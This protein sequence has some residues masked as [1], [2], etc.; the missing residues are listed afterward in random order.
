MDPR[1][2]KLIIK[3]PFWKTAWFIIFMLLVSALLIFWLIRYRGKQ[4]RK[5]AELKSNY[6]NKM[7][8]LEMQN[9]RSQMNPHFIFNSLNSINSFIVENKTHLASDYLTK[10]SKLI[11]LILDNSRNEVISL[12]RELETLQL[13]LLMETLRFDQKFGFEVT[14][15]EKL[16][17]EAVRIPPMIIQPYVENAIWHGLMQKNGKGQVTVALQKSADNQFLLIT[18][19]DNGVGR[20][21]ATQLSSKTGS[22]NKSFGMEITRNR[23][24]KLDPANSVKISDLKDEHGN[25]CGTRVELTLSLNHSAGES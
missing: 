22:T 7:L 14:V 24:A 1:A 6:E 15:D 21:R 9:L 20:E 17:R 16:D 4:I 2:I 11:R 5:E 19:C 23:I 18:V 8:H 12:D 13:Y 10:F 3:G 25:A